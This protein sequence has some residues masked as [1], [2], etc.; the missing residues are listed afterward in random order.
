M[1]DLDYI[2]VGAGPAGLQMAYFLAQSGKSYVMVEK[3]E[4]VG[5]FFR[6]YPRHRT[7]ISINKK[8][9]GFTDPEMNLRWDWNSLLND[10]VQYTDY[11][12]RYFP[13]ADSLCDYL[14]DFTAAHQLPVKHGFEVANISKTAGQFAVTSQAGETLNAKKLIVASGFNAE[15]ALDCPGSE[16]VE[17]YSTFDTN[18]DKYLN[19]RVL[20]LGKGNSAFEVADSLVETAASV[21]LCSNRSVKLAWESHYV[22]D[23]RAVNNNFLDTY[24]L[25]SQ[26][27]VLDADIA[28]ISKE[29]DQLR[30]DIVYSHA[31][32]ETRTIYYDHIIS[33][34]G[35]RFDD[36]IFDD[37][38]KPQL[39]V[40]KKFPALNPDWSSSNV[41]DLY[42]AGV[43]MHSLDY[44]KTMSGF[45]HGFRYNIK[46]LAAILDQQFADVK[47][48][49]DAIELP[50]LALAEHLGQRLTLSS[51]IFLQ[52]GFFGDVLLQSTDGKMRYIN[53]V[54][55]NYF[56]QQQKAQGFDGRFFTIS[57]EYGD[58]SLVND[59][60]KI[61]R[62]PDPSQAHLAE[63]IHPIIREYVNGEVKD[64][65]HL[66]E[67]LENV[68][69]RAVFT[70]LLQDFLVGK[71]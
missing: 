61:D 33:A 23:V 63:Y 40:K 14:E 48:C 31:M 6:T 44:K 30:V 12:D 69:T 28:S 55:L 17:R 42:F 13:D 8:N 27:V 16:L 52:P 57:L 5:S 46:A 2:I 65:F 41:D 18:P 53:D 36:S 38:C 22:G 43:L 68:Y 21:H 24:Q 70:Q 54:P 1:E 26:N 66:A 7:L 45:I 3:G 19:K 39:C 59:P 50:T 58:W 37:S 4:K 32:G 60:F 35:F 20:I 29:G 47:T 67:D 9:T 10:K 64:T 51:A 71:L 15:N 25:K 11:S 62:D 34:I 49:G 56:Y